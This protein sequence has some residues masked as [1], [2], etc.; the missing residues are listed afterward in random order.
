MEQAAGRGPNELL[1]VEVD[2][3]TIPALWIELRTASC[4]IVLKIHLGQKVG[5][6]DRRSRIL[7]FEREISVSEKGRIDFDQIESTGAPNGVFRP[8]TCLMTCA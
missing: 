3:S 8:G 7:V 6:H 1:L 5:F 2:V 4:R